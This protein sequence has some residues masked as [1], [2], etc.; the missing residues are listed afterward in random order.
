MRIGCI[1]LC[2]YN[3]FSILAINCKK[4]R[5][6]ILPG[7]GLEVKED[8]T[9]LET[10]KECCERELLEETGIQALSIKWLF[11]APNID[12]VSGVE[13]YVHSFICLTDVK[14]YQLNKDYGSGPMNIVL[15][16]D[17]LKSQF[18]GYY[19]CMFDAYDRSLR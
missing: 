18:R 2:P 7:G 11:G 9:P 12:P 19:E 1:A 16:G 4:G 3:S 13:Y 14:Q 17:L 8:G 6:W 10:L 15:R 5:G